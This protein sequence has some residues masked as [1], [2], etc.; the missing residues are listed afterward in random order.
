MRVFVAVSEILHLFWMVLFPLHPP[1]ASCP[2]CRGSGGPIPAGKLWELPRTSA[3]AALGTGL[4]LQTCQARVPG[5]FGGSW[6]ESGRWVLPGTEANTRN[7]PPNRPNGALCWPGVDC[8]GTGA[9]PFQPPVLPEKMQPQRGSPCS[10]PSWCRLQTV[11]PCWPANGAK[12]PVLSL[13]AMGRA[14]PVQSGQGTRSP[15]GV[16]AQGRTVGWSRGARWAVTAG[17]G[18]CRSRS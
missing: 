3:V 5:A 6:Q 7:Y 16:G 17:T 18:T 15:A 8:Q 9:A 13:G 11:V 12:C 2:V 14:G 1:H 4:V 10:L